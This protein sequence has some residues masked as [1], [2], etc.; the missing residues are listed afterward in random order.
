[1]Q[2]GKQGTFLN[3]RVKEKKLDNHITCRNRQSI[4]KKTYVAGFVESTV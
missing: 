2:L 1:M 3:C 4:S